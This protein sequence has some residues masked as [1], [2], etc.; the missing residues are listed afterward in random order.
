[1][2]TKFLRSTN[3]SLLFAAA[4]IITVASGKAAL[5][6]E[7]ITGEKAENVLY[8]A[9][10]ANRDET[11]TSGI[12]RL[13]NRPQALKNQWPTSRSVYAAEG[14]GLEPSTPCGATDFES[15]C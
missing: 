10:F 13:I 9:E 8:S 5:A 4:W 7:P 11:G 14:K 12:P 2:C 6:S 15:V 1:M 3:V